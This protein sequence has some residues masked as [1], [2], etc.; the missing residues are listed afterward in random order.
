MITPPQAYACG[1][2]FQVFQSDAGGT[3]KRGQK[4]RG[5]ADRGF[6]FRA[7]DPYPTQIGPGPVRTSSIPGQVPGS[8]RQ[9]L[10][11]HRPD[12]ARS[13]QHSAKHGFDLPGQTGLDQI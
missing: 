12:R 1:G 8:F 6:I 13:G 7:S 3:S 10:P 5:P 9:V 2:F 11:K 4:S